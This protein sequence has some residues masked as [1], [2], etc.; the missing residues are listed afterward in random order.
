M[1]EAIIPVRFIT[2]RE[3]EYLYRYSL[4]VSP[5]SKQAQG[6]ECRR[7]ENKFGFEVIRLDKMVQPTNPGYYPGMENKTGTRLDLRA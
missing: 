2:G 7:L 1:V 6:E 5:F 3:E 4:I